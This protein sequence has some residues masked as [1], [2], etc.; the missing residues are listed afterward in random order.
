MRSI[1][2][3][4]DAIYAWADRLM[5]AGQASKIDEVLRRLKSSDLDILLG[6]LTA[7]LPMKKRL[8]NRLRLYEMAKEIDPD[9]RLL[10]GLEA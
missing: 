4:L 7:T 6:F 5:W 8:P 1:D 9:P 10:Q 3:R 2:A